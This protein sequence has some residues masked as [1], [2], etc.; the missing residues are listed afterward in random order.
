MVRPAL[1][2]MILCMDSIVAQTQV[3]PD[4]ANGEIIYAFDGADTCY[5]IVVGTNILQVSGDALA[6][7]FGSC[8]PP[9]RHP[10]PSWFSQDHPF[11]GPPQSSATCTSSGFAQD[12]SIGNY[13]SSTA[14]YTVNNEQ[15]CP[16]RNELGTTSP[17]SVAACQA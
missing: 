16:G 10:P 4:N 12:V 17:G 8:A 3:D 2:A 7:Q 13:A 9:T 6:Y 11:A 15:A 14:A 5:K 1:F